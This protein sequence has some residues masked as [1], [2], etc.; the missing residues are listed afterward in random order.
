MLPVRWSCPAPSASPAD[1]AAGEARLADSATPDATATAGPAIAPTRI[2]R[3]RRRCALDRRKGSSIQRCVISAGTS[4]ASVTARPS[5][6]L[7]GPEPE[8]A[9]TSTGQ[10]HTYHA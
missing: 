5:A 4:E 7:G 6:V 3:G 2:A 10:C 8:A 9:N 1:S